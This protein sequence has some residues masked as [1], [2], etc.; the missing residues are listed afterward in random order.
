MGCGPRAR[1]SGLAPANRGGVL[2]HLVRP[3]RPLRGVNHGSPGFIGALRSSGSTSSLVAAPLVSED[4]ADGCHAAR[5]RA[6]PVT[7]AAPAWPGADVEATAGQ[8]AM[9]DLGAGCVKIIATGGSCRRLR[10][11]CGSDDR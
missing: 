6:L 8:Y 7:A 5:G 11:R 2:I 4:A 9:A 10:E 3:V 1:Q